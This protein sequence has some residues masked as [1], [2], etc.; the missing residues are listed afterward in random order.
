MRV[1]KSIPALQKIIFTYRAKGMTVGFVPTMGALHEGHLSLLQKARQENDIVLLSIF[2]NPTQF[3]PSEDLARYPREEK[4]DKLLAKKENVD[5]IFYPTEKL[6][7][8]SG[9]LTYVMVEVLDQVLCGA[10]RPGH[11]RGVATVVTKLLNVTTPT[12][13]YLGQKDAQQAILL[14]RMVVD[15]NF[16]VKVKICPIIREIDGLAMSSRNQYL[17]TTQRL[18]APVLYQALKA[19]RQLARGGQCQVA[20]IKRKIT[21]MIKTQPAAR[22]EYVA[23]VDAQTL[24][25]INTISGEVLIAVAVK[26][27]RT[28]LI[29]NVILSVNS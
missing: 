19:A 17:T 15:L 14:R 7:Y 9:Y 23:L 26:F 20:T 2:V 21:A 11:F 27:G 18:Q 8:P 24:Q 4:K 16:P 6:M 22:I 10:Y 3:A 13:M 12:I 28:R 5:I 25:P 1:I 29:D